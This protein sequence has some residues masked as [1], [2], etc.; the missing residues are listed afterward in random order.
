MP[1]I[2]LQSPFKYMLAGLV[3]LLL[4]SSVEAAPMQKK[5]GTCLLRPP[6]SKL[7]ARSPVVH[8][9]AKNAI[10]LFH[11]TEKRA[12]AINM[13]QGVNL[14]KT[15][16][17]GD[18]HDNQLHGSDG[19]AYFTDSVVAAA[20]FSCYKDAHDPTL[21]PATVHVLEFTWT[22]GSRK[23]YEFTDM[24]A[25]SLAQCSTHDMIAGPMG[26]P[27]TDKYLTPDFWQYALVKQSATTGLA[28][29]RTYQVHCKNVRQKH[30]L[31][32]ELYM[33]GQGGNPKF[34][35]LVTQLTSASAC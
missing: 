10:T 33:Q 20:Q 1:S 7:R 19:G 32:P 5:S 21:V 14:S 22:P 16:D 29:R 27:V 30:G 13:A 18:F 17:C 24:R 12:N 25:F 9:S 31:T 3:V 26:D 23:V 6:Q 8:P 34:Q 15:Y 28:Y 4:L 11:G 35:E 2:R